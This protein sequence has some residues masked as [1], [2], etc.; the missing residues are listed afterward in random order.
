MFGLLTMFTIFGGFLYVAAE[1][2]FNRADR[3]FVAS[4][5]GAAHIRR[6]EYQA[7]D[8]EARKLARAS[9]PARQIPWFW[10]LVV[11]AFLF[12]FSF[13]SSHL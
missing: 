5:P 1:A 11:V 8:R 7:R 12:G 6:Q 10:L 3:E 13:V 2:H 9:D 4:V